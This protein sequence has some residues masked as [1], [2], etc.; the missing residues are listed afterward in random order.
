M[1]LNSLQIIALAL[2]INAGIIP[3]IWE[4]A[5]E[6][7]EQLS[8]NIEKVSKHSNI[9]DAFK[10]NPE[11]FKLHADLIN[12]ESISGNE[13]G[14]SGY[15][16][17]YLNNL[18]LGYN[19]EIDDT[20]RNIY[21]FGG[22]HK[23]NSSVLL[24][25][26]I[27][28]VPPYVNYYVEE[29]SDDGSVKI[30]GRGSCD[31]K[32]SVAAQVIAAKELIEEGLVTIDELS[33]LFVFGEEV[34]G[35]GMRKSNDYFNK[36]NVTWDSVIFG[37]PTENKL[38]AGHKGIYMADIE[39]FGLA[40]HSGYPDVGID[41]D[42]ILIEIMHELENYPWPSSELLNKTT[43]NI[44]LMNGGTAGNVVSPYAKCSV[45]MRTAVDSDEIV[46]VVAEIVSKYESYA[47]E[48][49]FEVSVTDDPTSL[50]YQVK[51]FEKYIASYATDIPKL[52]HKGFKR[53]LYGPGS[54]LVAH[55]DNEYV[56][57]DSLLEAVDGYKKLV[58]YS[59]GK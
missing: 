46:P 44:G 58:L 1:L 18:G 41:A 33:L 56:T 54:I 11:L 17:R 31:A 48:L 32:G 6:S 24:T 50:D 53:Y 29:D 21:A 5:I 12:I 16:Q 9:S 30:H 20:N 37:E 3:N 55:G 15:L 19:F 8:L 35:L 27:D 39:V 13:Y 36:E 51:G 7:I 52:D 4:E 47:K 10:K 59:L 14:V 22:E 49:K 23:Q 34:G 43:I 2:T 25:S 26:H 38:A 57:A 45:L 28:T 40:S 42:K